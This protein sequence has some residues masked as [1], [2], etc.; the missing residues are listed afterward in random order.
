MLPPLARNSTSVARI[1]PLLR[2]SPSW[3]GRRTTTLPLPSEP[4]FNST[5][6][7]DAIAAVPLRAV[8][9]PSLRTWRATRTTSPFDAPI[10]PRLTTEALLLPL[11]VSDPPARNSASFTSSVEATKLPPVFTTPLGPTTTPDGLTR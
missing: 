11:K 7:P 10:L 5:S 8:S 1:A 4:S 6:L 3:A 9:D 2:I